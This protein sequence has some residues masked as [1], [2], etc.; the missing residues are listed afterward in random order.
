[1]ELTQFQRIKSL[2]PIEV[3]AAFIALQ[4][5]INGDELSQVPGAYEGSN[6]H[7]FLMAILIFFLVVVNTILLFRGGLRDLFSLSFSSAGFIIWAA[8]ID[9]VRWQDQISL[10]GVSPNASQILL[11]ILAVLYSLLAAVFAA[12]KPT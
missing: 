6:D 7:H 8:N 11:P 3:T 12:Q 5:I 4:T 10:L 9:S 1:M 2:L